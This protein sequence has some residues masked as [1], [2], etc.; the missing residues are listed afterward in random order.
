MKRNVAGTMTLEAVAPIADTPMVSE[1]T[2]VLVNRQRLSHK[3]K[4]RMKKHSKP[5][6]FK[7]DRY[8]RAVCE[9]FG[10]Q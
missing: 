3:Q 4:K 9:V 5:R 1:Y 8:K 7:N 2:H 6:R 10:K